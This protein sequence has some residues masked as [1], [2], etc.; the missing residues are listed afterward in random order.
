MQR[1]F[2][3]ASNLKVVFFYIVF[4]P[5]ILDLNSLTTA[6]IALASV[7]TLV[8]LMLGLMLIAISLLHPPDV[9]SS[10]KV[11]LRV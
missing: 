10:L 5:T 4:L 2:I 9:F 6:Y 3:S 11:R 7:L 8:G 1:F